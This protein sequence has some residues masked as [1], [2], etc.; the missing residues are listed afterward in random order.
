[1][2]KKKYLKISN[3]WEFNSKVSEVFDQHVRESIPFY[4][5][6][7]KQIAKISEFYLKDNSIIYDLGCS[8]GNYIKEVCKLKKK[9]LNIYGVDESKKMLKLA[10]FKIK[11]VNKNKIKFINN[12]LLKLK[13]FKSDLIVCSLMLPFFS[14]SKQVQLIKK[15]YNNLN[16]GGAAIFLNKSIC[17]HSH[18]ENIFNQLYYDFKL[19][20]GVRPVDVLKKAKSLRSVHTLNTTQEDTV[21][22]K[23][24]GFKKIDIFFKYLNFTGFLVEK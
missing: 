5:Q 15:I 17:R 13:M 23:K 12:D 22:L 8:T 24:I 10:N 20:M 18:F 16:V 3:N 21:L 11:N 1:M 6:F 2:K 7:H 19:S 4:N 14:R 9:N